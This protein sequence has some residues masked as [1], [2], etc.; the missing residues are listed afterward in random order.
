MEHTI[1]LK[2]INNEITCK[3][4][5]GYYIKATSINECRHICINFILLHSHKISEVHFFPVCKSCIIKYL[6]DCNACPICKT[7]V[8]PV[9]SITADV[10]MQ[11]L[12]YNLVPGLE[13][14]KEMDLNFFVNDIIEKF[15]Y[16]N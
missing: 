9:D 16:L 15:L 13:Q 3:L 7:I 14:S 1:L 10:T 2:E 6:R 8:H 12:V 4:C 5:D 11:R